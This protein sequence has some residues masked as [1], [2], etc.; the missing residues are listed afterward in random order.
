MSSQQRSKY[1]TVYRIVFIGLMAAIVFVVSMF[2]FPFLG[3][4]IHFGNTMCLLS[5]L[6]FGPISGG[7]SAGIG[8]TLVDVTSGYP[9]W[10]A[11]ITFVSKFAMGAV[12]GL[13]G[14]LLRK[15]AS[16]RAVRIVFVVIG[17]IA[18]AVSYVF[19]Y[20]LKHFVLQ[21][22][23]YGSSWEATMTVLASK[24][25]ASAINA[26][27]AIVC[28]PLLFLALYPALIRL[29]FFAEERHALQPGADAPDGQAGDGDDPENN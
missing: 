24:F 7:L 11:I 6:L 15:K 25:P 20:M 8:S 1:F 23:V 18:G 16:T 26:G 9:F 27:F 12:A 29:P 13:I 17:G 4:K 5:G 2:R 28:A 21:L 3:S 10:E 14:C 19:L 22:F